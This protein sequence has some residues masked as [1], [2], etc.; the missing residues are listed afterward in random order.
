MNSKKIC[1]YC[2]S[3]MHQEDKDTW[4][5]VTTV[6]YTCRNCQGRCI[7]SKSGKRVIAE[8]WERPEKQ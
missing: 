5:D 4:G 6:W 2:G 1:K 7:A 8:C 3:E